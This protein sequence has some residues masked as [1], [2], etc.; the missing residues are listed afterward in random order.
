MSYKGLLYYT[1]GTVIREHRQEI[2]LSQ[3]DLA[4][5]AGSSRQHISDVENGKKNPSFELLVDIAL[6]LNKKPS[7][8]IAD[9]ETA[10]YNELLR[11]KKRKKPLD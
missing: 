10:A 11:L 9:F 7:T 5:Y 3:E 8:L 2:D 6:A 1:I 4:Y